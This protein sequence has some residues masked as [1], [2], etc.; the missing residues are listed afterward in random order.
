[1]RNASFV[2]ILLM[3]VCLGATAQ[4]AVSY[5]YV[6]P[7]SFDW[8]HH[9][10]AEMMATGEILSDQSPSAY[11]VANWVFGQP[12][13]DH[14]LAKYHTPMSWT[15][16]FPDGT[17]EENIVQD[18]G[19]N[20]NNLREAKAYLLPVGTAPSAVTSYTSWAETDTAM[21]AAGAVAWAWS[22]RPQV[23]G[24]PV[25][26][27]RFAELPRLGD[28][29]GQVTVLGHNWTPPIGTLAT[30][31]GS[32]THWQFL[33]YGSTSQLTD[34]FAGEIFAC[35]YAGANP[36]DPAGGPLPTFNDAL[37]SLWVKR[38]PRV[39]VT[40]V[41]AQGNFNRTVK[42]KVYGVDPDAYS[43]WLYDLI[44]GRWL[45]SNDAIE[46]AAD[47]TLEAPVAVGGFDSVLGQYASEFAF[48]LTRFGDQPIVDCNSILVGQLPSPTSDYH[49]VAVSATIPASSVGMSSLSVPWFTDC[50]KK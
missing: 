33:G 35:Y 44:V 12:G 4:T 38:V 26:T 2:T 24:A 1:M 32:G 50:P 27:L 47:G 49:V 28:P 48:V 45:R 23:I 13:D 39:E 8:G 43:G 46:I 5:G 17:W 10:R 34:A 37:A 25:P 6:P 41:P 31:A 9:T 19:G 29:V 18:P 11:V 16:I 14:Y 3:A 15:P 40:A 7:F 42:G 30:Y 22:V 36:I 21:I 20:D